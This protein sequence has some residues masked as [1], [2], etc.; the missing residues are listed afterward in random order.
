M[1][2]NS[3]NHRHPPWVHVATRSVAGF[4]RFRG[5][6]WLKNLNCLRA[7]R[8]SP[9]LPGGSFSLLRQ[10]ELACGRQLQPID[11]FLVRDDQE[12]FASK[13]APAADR[14]RSSGTGMHGDRTVVV[15]R[16]VSHSI[17]A[18]LRYPKYIPLCNAIGDRR[19]TVSSNSRIQV[20]RLIA[21]RIHAPQAAQWLASEID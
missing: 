18:S 1:H 19:Q 20:V 14:S 13:E 7:G 6:G 2:T 15:N 5:S 17:P 10:N 4:L 12:P 8:K 3:S 16:F 9:I 11:V 21:A